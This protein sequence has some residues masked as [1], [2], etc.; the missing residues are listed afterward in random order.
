MQNCYVWLTV[1][2]HQLHSYI[3]LLGYPV[4]SR[5]PGSWR[6]HYRNNLLDQINS[7]YF[8]VFILA[9]LTILW[10]MTERAILTVSRA[11]PSRSNKVIILTCTDLRYNWYYLPEV[12]W[13]YSSLVYPI[14]RVMWAITHKPTHTCAYM[15]M[16]IYNSG[17]ITLWWAAHTLMYIMQTAL[18]PNKVL[19]SQTASHSCWYN[20]I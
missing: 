2:H 12:W 20:V 14:G 5:H 1:L 18:G 13:P 16:Y 3:Y 7:P 4:N 17:F 8:G 9:G 6:C 10:L 11:L 19:L 15:Y